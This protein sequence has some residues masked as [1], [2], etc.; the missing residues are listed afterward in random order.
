MAVLSEWG[1]CV[2][3]KVWRWLMEVMRLKAACKA[4]LAVTSWPERCYVKL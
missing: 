1:E 3:A 2:L 4:S